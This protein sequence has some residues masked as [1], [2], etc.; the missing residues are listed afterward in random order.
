MDAEILKE[1]NQVKGMYEAMKTMYEKLPDDVELKF[2]PKNM[3]DMCDLILMLID[4]L[5]K[6]DK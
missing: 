6:E 4:E 2:S 1:L 3:T 5:L